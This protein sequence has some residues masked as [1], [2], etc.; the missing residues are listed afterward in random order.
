MF[1]I[2]MMSE[3]VTYDCQLCKWRG[4]RLDQHL[5]SKKHKLREE[6]KQQQQ[7]NII[8]NT[9]N[10]EFY[11][12]YAIINGKRSKKR[13]SRT[14][15]NKDK[16]DVYK[17]MEEI[18]ETLLN[19]LVSSPDEPFKC[20]IGLKY[21]RDH[22]YLSK[23]DNGKYRFYYQKDGNYYSISNIESLEKALEIRDKFFIQRINK[24]NWDD[25]KIEM[26]NLKVKEDPE[27]KTENPNK[28]LQWNKEQNKWK[29]SKTYRSGKAVISMS[30]PFD[31]L[32]LARKFRDEFLIKWESKEITGLNDFYDFR[33]RFMDG[34]KNP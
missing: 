5:K 10:K 2:P 7:C 12:D 34:H 18:R 1:D 13:I 21:N 30:T 32:E 25:F 29:F 11:I 24:D 20:D 9:K 33:Q 6:G 22:M 28:Y 27:E 14:Y 19:H 8:E 17:T 23:Q 26:L 16:D 31:N 15:F 3:Q 4:A